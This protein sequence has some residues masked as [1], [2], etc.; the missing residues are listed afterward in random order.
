MEQPGPSSVTLSK[1]VHK[2]VF[3]L[4]DEFVGLLLRA[5]PGILPAVRLLEKFGGSW[6]RTREQGRTFV[7]EFT[8]TG[9]IT[10]LIGGIRVLLDLA[11]KAGGEIVVLDVSRLSRTC[12]A[13]MPPPRSLGGLTLLKDQNSIVVSTE[14]APA[15]V[16]KYAQKVLTT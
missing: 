3:L 5:P 12:R 10:A 15:D 1:A 9:T 6:S 14:A 8:G 2:V 7:R 4:S 11:E 13:G 16:V